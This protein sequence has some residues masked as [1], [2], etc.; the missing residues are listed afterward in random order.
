MSASQLQETLIAGSEDRWEAV[1]WDVRGASAQAFDLTGVTL[2][3]RYWYEADGA[4]GLTQLPLTPD[5]DQ[6][7]RKGWWYRDLAPSDFPKAGWIVAAVWAT[8]GARTW[9]SRRQRILVEESV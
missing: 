4:S 9:R 3:L 6:V 8:L 1:L 7:G 2:T 5:P